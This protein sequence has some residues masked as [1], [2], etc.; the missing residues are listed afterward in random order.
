MLFPTL[1]ERPCAPNPRV[2]IGR[3][4]GRSWRTD[5]GSANQ[6]QATKKNKIASAN[7]KQ[8]PKKKTCI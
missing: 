4:A 7:Q 5:P 1:G 6:P 3:A 2:L 8:A